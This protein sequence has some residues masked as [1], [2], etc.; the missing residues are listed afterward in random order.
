MFGKRNYRISFIKE[1]DENNQIVTD[2]TC[3]EFFAELLEKYDFYIPKIQL[4]DYSHCYIWITAYTR[5]I[6]NIVSLFCQEFQ[7]EISC[8]A[9]ERV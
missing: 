7:K 2:A 5:D 8:C 3:L 6:L 1:V 4:S 9:Y